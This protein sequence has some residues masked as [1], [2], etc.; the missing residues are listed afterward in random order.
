MILAAGLGERMRPLTL[1]TPKPLLAVG[2]KPMLDHAL[3]ALKAAGV[4]RVVVNTFH[5]AEQ[6]ESHLARRSDLEVLIVREAS[7][8][9][10]G[11]GVLNAR[12]RWPDVFG[13]SPFFVLNADLT[14][15]DGPGEVPAL[16][17]LA[18]FWKPRRMDIALL[19]METAKARGFPERGDFMR[20]PDG[21]LGRHNAPVPRSH[22]FISARIV[23]PTL[24]E[25]IT[26]RVFSM[27]RLFDEAEAR[28]RLF[29][30]EH[31]GTC[32]HVGTP[33]DLEAANRTR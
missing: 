26:E 5:L 15:E 19:V 6:I 16:T 13:P 33:H 8:L 25:G 7:L 10:S 4:R 27:N 28:G 9:D 32:F 1:T 21:R 24:F 23:S 12:Q 18:R 30:L 31:R 17:R 11:G 2:G 22:V 20:T 29:G 14:W 3:E